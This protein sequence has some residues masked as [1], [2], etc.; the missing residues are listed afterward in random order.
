MKVLIYCVISFVILFLLSFDICINIIVLSELK[1]ITKVY[2]TVD[3]FSQE[4][5]STNG[6]IKLLIEDIKTA[7]QRTG[8]LVT[9][10]ALFI[11]LTRNEWNAIIKLID[12]QEEANR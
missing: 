12:K 7:T 10:Q 1:G 5:N 8:E 3:S 9:T 4:V 6:K 2:K 11:E